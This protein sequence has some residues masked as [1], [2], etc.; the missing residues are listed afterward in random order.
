MT[1][2]ASQ[3]ELIRQKEMLETSNSERRE[4]MYMTEERSVSRY[5]DEGRKIKPDAAF[6]EFYEVHNRQV[7]LMK[8]APYQLDR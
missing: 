1:T 8:F 6:D 7:T 4:G 3:D 5:F 2:T